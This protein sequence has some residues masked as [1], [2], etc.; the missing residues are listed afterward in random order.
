[1][2][3]NGCIKKNLLNCVKVNKAMGEQKMRLFQAENLRQLIAFANENSLSKADC[4]QIIKEQQ[5]YVLI[6]FR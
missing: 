6:Y 4:F 2:D 5:G 1:M 3:I